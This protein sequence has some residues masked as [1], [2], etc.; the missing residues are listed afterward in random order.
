[1]IYLPKYRFA[2]IIMKK[3]VKFLGVDKAFYLIFKTIFA[4]IPMLMVSYG[5]IPVFKVLWQIN[6]LI[7]K[8][9]KFSSI[10]RALFENYNPVIVKTIMDALSP[11]WDICLKNPTL[12]KTLFKLFFGFYSLGLFRPFIYLSVKYTLG[13]VITSVGIALNEILY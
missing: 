3:V 2:A 6:K 4:Q 11:H 9:V 7:L 10:S 13:L 1:M 8:E 12:F 5:I